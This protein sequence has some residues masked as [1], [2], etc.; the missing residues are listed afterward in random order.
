MRKISEEEY[1][2][3]CAYKLIEPEIKGCLD[4]EKQHKQQLEKLKELND[5]YKNSLK[6]LYYDLYGDC[7]Q[8]SSCFRNSDERYILLN[9]LFEIIEKYIGKYITDL[10]V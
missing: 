9:D 7:Y 6:F 8:C 1:Q 10:G 4:R 3:Y 5:L 2:K